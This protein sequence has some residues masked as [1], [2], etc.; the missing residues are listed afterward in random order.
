[1]MFVFISSTALHN[2]SYSPKEP[3]IKNPK[4]RS[5]HMVKLQH[6][7]MHTGSLFFSHR[8][9]L[10]RKWLLKTGYCFMSAT[11][12]AKWHVRLSEFERFGL[13]T[14]GK[15]TRAAPVNCL[16]P[17]QVG[18]WKKTE[19]SCL[20]GGSL[21]CARSMGWHNASNFTPSK[22][23]FFGFMRHGAA[24]N[25]NELGLRLRLCIHGAA[26]QSQ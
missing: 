3:T 25:R 10:Q 13:I 26:S 20:A 12:P 16:I 9:S 21:S 6:H 24:F 1:M 7:V 4:S 8:P 17:I 22:M 19:V 23:N 18:T 5:G 2:Y 11:T 15:T 14:F